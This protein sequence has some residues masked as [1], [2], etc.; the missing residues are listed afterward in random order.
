MKPRLSQLYLLHILNDG[1]RTALVVLLPFI[2]KDLSLSLTQVGFLGSSQGLLMML[3]GIPAGLL[4]ARMGGLRLLSFALILYS[5]SVIAIAFSTSVALVVV[6][7]FAAAVGFGVFH[8][9][10]FASIA[11]YA[12]KDQ[13]G[14]SMGKFSSLGEIG[15]MGIPPTAILATSYFGWRPTLI[16]MGA[17]GCLLFLYSK[18]I[19]KI[20]EEHSSQNSEYHTD[21]LKMLVYLAKQPKILFSAFSN[22]ID[23]SASNIVTIFYPFV[24]LAKGVTPFMLGIMTGIYFIGGLCGKIVLGHRADKMKTSTLFIIAE[25]MMAILL[26]FLAFFTNL[27]LLFMISFCLGI[28][29]KGTSSVVQ[30]LISESAQ[31]GHFE[32]VFS[33][34]ETLSGIAAA[35]APLIAGVI[36]DSFGVLSTLYLAAIVALLAIV[37]AYLSQRIQ[38]KP[39][40]T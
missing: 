27:Y 40:L 14:I 33:I 28:F 12:P 4:A 13:V 22:M 36:A 2:A 19:S 35:T 18:Y 26:L 21:W 5:I 37:P 3:L 20:P 9:V 1:V 16:V 30:T 8:P 7:F 6:A 24:I 10:G 15:R 38:R 11:K 29:T 25:L 23:A 17:I 31:G 34:S 39:S 32:K